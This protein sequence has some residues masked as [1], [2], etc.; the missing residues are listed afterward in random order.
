MWESVRRKLE[1]VGEV[2]NG[3]HSHLSVDQQHRLKGRPLN[4]PRITEMLAARGGVNAGANSGGV[5][6]TSGAGQSGGASAEPNR[7]EH[8]STSSSLQMGGSVGM[9]K[10]A[11]ETVSGSVG[12]G[13]TTDRR[14]G[15]SSQAGIPELT[16]DPLGS[17]HNSQSVSRELESEALGSAGGEGNLSGSLSRG[18]TRGAG[19][20]SSSRGLQPGGSLANSQSSGGVQMTGPG[21][22]GLRMGTGLQE[23][24]RGSSDGVSRGA[25]GRQKRPGESSGGVSEGQGARD[26]C[27][28][29]GT[30]DAV[31]L[32]EV[33][34]REY[35]EALAGGRPDLKRRR[36]WEEEET[37][38]KVQRRD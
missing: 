30:E 20:A 37:L 36:G 34:Q 38:S 17:D 28:G 5:A 12:G 11:S 22:Q 3:V 15:T 25:E 27:P 14:E 24:S 16:R 8:H 9:D 4:Q 32:H 6:E 19:A 18:E 2:L 23:C 26:R 29:Q 21:V 7:K 35:E 1:N 13:V 31:P 33:L 10:K